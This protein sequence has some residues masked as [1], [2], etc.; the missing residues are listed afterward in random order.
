MWQAKVTLKGQVTIPMAVRTALAIHEGDSV[1]FAVE[2]DQAILRPLKR[3]P[4]PE[5]YGA[6]PA[7]RPYPGLETVRQ[8]VRQKR[9]QR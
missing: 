1:L 2:G 4:L 9:A 5:L 8:E 3:K 7:T 6:L